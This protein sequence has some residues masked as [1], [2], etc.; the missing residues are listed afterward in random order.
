M[1]KI[2]ATTVTN[3]HLLE[4]L[5]GA[6]ERIILVSP[7]IKLNE[8]I[9]YVLKNQRD[10]GLPIDVIC[11]A[12]ELK[13]EL[14]RLQEIATR[15]YDLP[16]LHAK[17][18]LNESE[19][20]V[21]SLNLYEYS[22]KNNHELGI[23]IQTAPGST[24]FKARLLAKL[25]LHPADPARRLFSEIENEVK[26]LF[27]QG[28][29]VFPAP[30]VPP[31]PAPPKAPGKLVVGGNYKRAQLNEIFGFVSD[32]SFGI[33]LTRDGK[34]IALFSNPNSKFR[35]IIGKNGIYHYQGDGD[36][37][38][39]MTPQE[40]ALLHA[41][42]TGTTEIHLFIS[43]KYEGQFVFAGAPYSSANPPSPSAGVP[44][45]DDEKWFFPLRK[46]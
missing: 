15:I 20:I 24:D 36:G 2:I 27:E 6:K 30:G 32:I 13:D 10:A 3:A 45:H 26:T 31:T 7:F 44:Y 12:T 40:K 5:K 33:K 28:N 29:K 37:P 43:M 21:T 34:K 8:E 46:K 42:E 25:G 16:D 19:A 1:I 38:P 14:S 9:Y 22:Q 17:C 23:L 18:Y 39:K 11:R 41:Y 4:L 35:L